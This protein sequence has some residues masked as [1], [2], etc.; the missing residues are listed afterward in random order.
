[1]RPQKSMVSLAFMFKADLPEALTPH[2]LYGLKIFLVLVSLPLLKSQP[3]LV[4]LLW[5]PLHP[6]KISAQVL[7]MSSQNTELFEV[8]LTLLSN[9]P[10][11]S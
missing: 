7:V 5:P 1:M 10:N 3:G 2:M 4:F 9:C 6:G 8:R 11:L